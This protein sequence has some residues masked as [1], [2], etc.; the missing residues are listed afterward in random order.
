MY[1]QDKNEICAKAFEDL[2]ITGNC[3]I[4]GQSFT[5][6]SCANKAVVWSQ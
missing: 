3:S 1:W 4:C 2:V 6:R 5:E